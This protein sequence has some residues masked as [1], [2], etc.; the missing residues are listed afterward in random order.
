ME[1]KESKKMKVMDDELYYNIQ[2]CISSPNVYKI[3][4]VDLENIL[5]DEPTEEE[6]KELV[7][8]LI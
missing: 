7:I 8:Y 4:E 6:F 3:F 5:D 2:F 1:T